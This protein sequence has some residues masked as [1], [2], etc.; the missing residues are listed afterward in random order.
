MIGS[1]TLDNC[2]DEPIHTPGAIQPHGAL[3][4]FD[5]LGRLSHFSRNAAALLGVTPLLGERFNSERL[6]LLELAPA[7][8]SALEQA[9]DAGARA[10]AMVASLGGA[11]YDVVI[12]AHQGHVICEFESRVQGADVASFA[13]IAFRALEELKRETTPEGLLQAA[14]DAARA[15]TGFDRVMGYRF[16]PDDSGEVV[17]EARSDALEPF[18][19]RRYPA[20]DIPAQARRLYVANTLRLIADIRYEPVPVMASPGESQPLDMSFSVLRSVSPIH[21]EYLTNMGVGASLSVSIVMNGRLWGMLACHHMTARQV[22]YPIRMALDVMAQVVSS[23][24]QAI[25]SRIREE[26]SARAAVLRAD[27]ARAVASGEGVVEAVERQGAAVR[28]DLA[29]DA[30]FC[31]HNGGARAV[32]DVDTRWAASVAEWLATQPQ[33]FVHVADGAALP[34]WPDDVPPEQ[35][36]AGLLAV[37]YDLVQQGWVVALRREEIHTIRWGG[38]PE[39]VVAHG[40]NGP[41]LTPRGSFEEWRETVRGRARPWND[42]EL[43][44]AAHFGDS[45]AR[46]FAEHRLHIEAMRAQLWAVLGHDLRNPLHSISVA[47]SAMDKG[48]KSERLNTVIKN[49]A[50]RMS[51]LLSDVLDLSRLHRG[52]ELTIDRENVDLA[53]L[54]R[55]L[56]EE[57]SVAH[58]SIVF[59]LDMPD[60]VWV[61]GDIERLAQ[62][63]ANLFSNARHHG[64][65]EVVVEIGRD[66]EMVVLRVSNESPPIPENLVPHLFDPFKSTSIGKFSNKTGMGLGLYIAMQVVK[67][68]GGTIAYKPGAGI[69][70]FE[71]RLPAGPVP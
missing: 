36:F 12:H 48:I 46:A 69:V 22:A 2:D 4:A 44:I 6:G 51:R 47:S 29:C 21:V 66:G 16:A 55:Q 38:K 52:F 32:A 19:G 10:P 9:I 49:S 33:N 7:V 26:A 5:R 37:R 40:P 8:V 57:S 50:N 23:R 17:A 45:L 14:A 54:V 67:A 27:L 62:L 64:Q 39:K 63:L 59:D 65:G 13:L 34:A 70:S 53:S 18:L 31:I 11:A 41:R 3:L 71:V 60:T 43:E 35:R 68:H 58:P 42:V 25:V 15:I 20:S 24:V 1:V 28:H 30:L 61:V 56:A